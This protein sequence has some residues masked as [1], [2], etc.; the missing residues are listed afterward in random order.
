MRAAMGLVV[1]EDL[2][3]KHPIYRYPKREASGS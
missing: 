2:G 3:I 1:E